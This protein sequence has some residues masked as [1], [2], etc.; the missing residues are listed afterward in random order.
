MRAE[1][2]DCVVSRCSTKLYCPGDHTYSVVLSRIVFS[3]GHTT[4]DKTDHARRSLLRPMSRH[5]LGYS[6]SHGGAG[7]RPG[8]TSLSS[9]KHGRHSWKAPPIDRVCDQ[10]LPA[11]YTTEP[12]TFVIRLP[13]GDDVH[14]YL[15]ANGTDVSL[16]IKVR[17]LDARGPRTSPRRAHLGV[18]ATRRTFSLINT[19]DQP[20]SVSLSCLACHLPTGPLAQPQRR[21]IFFVVFPLI[22]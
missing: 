20:D 9:R 13:P 14:F 2:L 8:L 5:L 21:Y 18:R 11:W 1:H 12:Q 7:R 17:S 3:L 15:F 19:L 16:A 6:I 10:L 4:I 22:E